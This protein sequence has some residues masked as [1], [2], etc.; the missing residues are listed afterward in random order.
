MID[1]LPS[2]LGL[3]VGWRPELALAISRRKNLQFVEII[4]E[5]FQSAREIPP[6][7]E[8]LR[9]R[10]IAVVPHGIRLSLGS[11]EPPD[12]NRLS[13]LEG[14]AQQFNSPLVSEHLA[15][16]RAGDIE[17]GHLLPVPRTRQMLE[18]VVENVRRAQDRL[19]VPLALEN[20]ATHFEWP[21]AEFDEADFLT[22]VLE[23]SGALL[24]LDIENLYANS[25]NRGFDPVDVLRRMPLERLAYVHIAGGVERDGIYHDT[26]AHPIPAPVLQLLSELAGLTQIPGVLLERDEHFPD[27]SEFD[28]ELDRIANAAAFHGREHVHC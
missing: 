2:L 27:E 28:A 3:G 1:R 4:A 26:H 16:V 8:Q 5:H 11:A 9:D 22:E 7:I 19:S 24:L 6:S 18:I 25:V 17:S 10:G 21:E 20:I 14:I 23:R 15:F 12:T 13:Q